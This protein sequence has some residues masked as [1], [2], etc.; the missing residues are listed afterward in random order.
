M[1]RGAAGAQPAR[2]VVGSRREGGPRADG[3]YRDRPRARR[4]T[5]SV[6]RDRL[7]RVFGVGNFAKA[8]RA[9]LEVEAI[10]AA[11][12][13]RSRRHDQSTFRLSARR[14]DK[15]FPLTSPQ[16]EREV[17][18]RIKEARNWT[19]NLSHPELTIHVEALTDEAFY[20]FGKDRGPGGLPVGLE[21][22]GGVPAVGRHR[23]AGRGVADD[24]ARLPRRCSCTST[25][26]RCCRGP[27][28]RRRGSWW[29]TSRASS[30]RRGCCSCPSAS[31]SSRSS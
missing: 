30:T 15:R 8:G 21:R 6:V 25:A 17:G 26:I 24:A 7:S 16:I 27:R 14:A 9:A 3:A 10:A 18:G 19:V 20:F 5:G 2:G 29:R 13:R 31:S 4:R 28:R 23:L 1:V 12:P 22:T 11:H